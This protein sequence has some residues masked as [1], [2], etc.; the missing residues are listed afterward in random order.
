M[1]HFLSFSLSF[2]THFSHR[3]RRCVCQAILLSYGSLH[4][5]KKEKNNKIRMKVESPSTF[6]GHGM[7]DIE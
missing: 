7:E 5:K 6:D 2:Y 1:Q 4:T 3:R